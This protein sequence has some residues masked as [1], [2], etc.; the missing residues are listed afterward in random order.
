MR[1][2][3]ITL[4]EENLGK[5]LSGVKHSRI[6]SGEPPRIMGIKAK[7]KQMGPT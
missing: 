1:P 3:T 6:L 5:T 7:L 4:L 2:Q